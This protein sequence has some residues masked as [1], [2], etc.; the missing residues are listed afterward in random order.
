MIYMQTDRRIPYRRQQARGAEAVEIRNARA[1]TITGP[2]PSP[3]RDTPS[4]S[5]TGSEPLFALSHA[6]DLIQV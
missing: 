1:V 5:S 6:E 2:T 3:E 4:T